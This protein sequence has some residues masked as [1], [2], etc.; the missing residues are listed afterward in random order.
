MIWHHH[1]CIEAY[2]I[3]QDRRPVPFFIDNL[4]E[5]IQPHRA[6][7]YLSEQTL[8]IH[9]ANC[10]EISSGSAVVEFSEPD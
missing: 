8:P 4:P 2:M 3:P 7:Y 1:E 9:R 10:Y 5:T 6:V